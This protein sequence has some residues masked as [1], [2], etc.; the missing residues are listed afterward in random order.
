MFL[1]IQPLWIYKQNLVYAAMQT[2]YTCV[3]NKQKL[4]IL[5]FNFTNHEQ[6]LYLNTRI[7]YYYK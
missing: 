1:N 7:W 4:Y 5:Y 6:N 3:H 2:K